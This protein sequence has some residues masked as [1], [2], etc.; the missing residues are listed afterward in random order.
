MRPSSESIPSTPT[1][2]DN[3]P[4]RQFIV[5]WPSAS[6]PPRPGSSALR[7]PM[8][9]PAS[10]PYRATSPHNSA[11][12]QKAPSETPV[13]IKLT[14]AS[15]RHH[16]RSH[17]A[18]RPT[19]TSGALDALTHLTGRPASAERPERRRVQ[20]ASAVNGLLQCRQ[21][22]RQHQPPRRRRHPHRCAH[23]AGCV[24][25]GAEGYRRVRLLCRRV[26]ASAVRGVCPLDLGLG[27]RRLDQRARRP[28]RGRHL[29]LPRSRE[30]CQRFRRRRRSRPG[31]HPRP[32]RPHRRPRRQLHLWQHRR[33]L[34]ARR[35][36]HQSHR[37]QMW[38]RNSLYRVSLALP[39]VLLLR[40][41]GLPVCYLQD[42]WGHLRPQRFRPRPHLLV[43]QRPRWLLLQPRWRLR[44]P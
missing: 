15:G 23:Q 17:R 1:L 13:V 26:G 22:P 34:G 20:Q 4:V 27:C 2:T 18:K 14:A 31:R 16:P 30:G 19:T 25:S 44:Q 7:P 33:R 3:W 21:R 43:P 9:R 10:P 37:P 38:L 42:R 41:L 29:R 24:A 5:P 11:R 12:S 32:R 39:Q 36:Y 8:P 28:H 35:T 6:S 40:L